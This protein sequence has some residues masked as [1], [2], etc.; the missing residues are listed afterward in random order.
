MSW[1]RG[2]RRALP[3]GEPD[4]IEGYEAVRGRD[5]TFDPISAALTQEEMT[6]LDERVSVD[7]ERPTDVAEGRLEEGGACSGWCLWFGRAE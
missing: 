1:A 4:R 6:A 7:R 5:Q 2:P 3:S